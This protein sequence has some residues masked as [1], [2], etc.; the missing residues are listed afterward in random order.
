MKLFELAVI[1]MQICDH[2][3]IELLLKE[4][5]P[6]RMLMVIIYADALQNNNNCLFHLGP[7]K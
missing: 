3:C 2:L 1:K 7:P 4:G 5:E 6:I